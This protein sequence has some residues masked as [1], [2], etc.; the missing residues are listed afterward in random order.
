MAGRVI[1]MRVSSLPEV[2]GEK[3]VMRILDRS[4]LV[5]DLKD[6]GFSDKTADTFKKLL[7]MPNG[8][9]LLTGPTG[10]GKTTTLYSALNILKSRERNIQTVEDPVEYEIEGINQMQIRP[11]VGLDFAMAL[12]SIL[13]QDPDVIL[14]G[15]IRDLE[16]ARIATRAAMTG[17]MV[18]SSL[19]T[20]DA[21]GA[22]SRLRDIGVESYLI[23]ASV[24]A[25]I[26]QR[27]VRRIC[28]ECKTEMEDSSEAK[29][30][31]QPYC[32]DVDSWTFYHGAGCERCDGRGYKG[33]TAIIEFLE[34]TESISDLVQRECNDREIRDEAIRGGMSPLLQS[35]FQRIKDGVTTLDEVLS[36]CTLTEL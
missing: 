16:T 28:T 31:L 3:I 4:S 25:V 13:R 35:G 32:P 26:S 9:I 12:R 5:V 14:I 22:F 36:V 19:H 8:I 33:R 20:N 34:V 29:Q 30:I 7:H 15:E 1:D 2:H 23:G 6:I 10:S 27:L 24:R 17:H 18:L 11:N 21:P